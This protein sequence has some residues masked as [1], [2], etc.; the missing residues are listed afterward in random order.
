MEVIAN[1]NNATMFSLVPVFGKTLALV[2]D[3]W[4]TAWVAEL[5]LVIIQNISI[6]L[7]KAESKNDSA[8]FALLKSQI[9]E[10][11]EY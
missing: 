3:F 8:F 2:L 9:Y 7:K 6:N 4:A 10:K 1:P 11:S 5:W